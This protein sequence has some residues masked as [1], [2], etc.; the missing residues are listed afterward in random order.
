[1]P[2]K[3]PDNITEHRITLGRKE[4]QEFKQTM[5]A[6]QFLA[7]GPPIAFGL[8]G[9]GIL[10][11]GYGIFR[12]S[13]MTLKNVADAVINSA[14]VQAAAAPI[15]DA[16]VAISGETN[17]EKMI[18]AWYLRIMEIR[19]QMEVLGQERQHMEENNIA[20]VD[21]KMHPQYRQIIDELIALSN[22]EV[23][24][25]D[26]INKATIGEWSYTGIDVPTSAWTPYQYLMT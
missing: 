6:A 13:G 15:S 11:A 18:Q 5:D 14:P 4:F 16:I 21:G 17:L 1:M 2:I 9:A 23:Q 7:L 24:L 19:D 26:Y 8:A 10:M 22:E 3:K 25:Y 12:W 20:F